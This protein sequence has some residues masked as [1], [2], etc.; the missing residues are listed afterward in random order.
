MNY[1]VEASLVSQETRPSMVERM[2]SILPGIIARADQAEELRKVPDENVA[3]L[4]EIGYLRGMVP[5][6]YGGGEEDLVDLYQAGRLLASACASTAWAMQLLMGH[7]HV[8]AGFSK[9]AQDDVWGNG[10]EANAASSIAPM[11]KFE[12]VE[13]GARLTG[14]YQFSSGCDH[15]DW[16]ILG[17]RMAGPDGGAPQHMLALVP[18]ADCQIVDTW[19]TS[20]LKGTGSKD[21]AVENVFIPEHRIEPI[22]GLFTGQ[23]RGAGT[24]PGTLYRVPF[25]SIFGAGFSVVAL[26][27]ADGMAEAY[28]QRLKGR[29]SAIT[30]QKHIDAMPSYMRLAE[31]AQEIYAA[32]LILEKDW[33]DFLALAEGR[34]DFTPDLRVAWRTNQAYAVKLATRATDRLFEAS[35]GGAGYLSNPAQ[36]FWR[37]IHMA[38]GHYYVDYDLAARI[39]GRHLIG[40]EPDPTLL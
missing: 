20:G 10:P 30:G 31:S 37:D 17:G 6:A 39:L 18:R 24:H 26:G 35:G 19:F 22:I 29:V 36:R 21:V 23:S 8:V 7:S 5:L 4:R 12:P 14:R 32:S 9:Q 13:G 11:G 34:I 2:R 33:R 28:K 16:I 25:S 40:L 27:A 15:A 3:A 38:G 1:A